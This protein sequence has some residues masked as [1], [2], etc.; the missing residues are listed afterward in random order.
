MSTPDTHKPRTPLPPPKLDDALY[1]ILLPAF[2]RLTFATVERVWRATLA[3]G[4]I[5]GRT[6]VI[7]LDEAPHA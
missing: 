4:T 7:P 5:T 1:D 6:L 3:S 2:G